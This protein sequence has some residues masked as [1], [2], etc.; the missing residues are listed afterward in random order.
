MA[1]PKIPRGPGGQPTKFTPEIKAK[2]LEAIKKGA[3]FELACSYA[4]IHFSTLMNWKRKAEDEFCPEYIKF[5]E[6]LEEAKGATALMWLEKIDKAMDEG[7][8]QAA[9]WKLAKRHSKH[10]S[11]SAGIIE[12][13]ERLDRLERLEKI[14]VDPCGELSN[15]QEEASKES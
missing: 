11:E 2:L 15:G 7:T 9:S 6:D 5:F 13:N 14:I 10:F 12:M 3:P 8:W 1:E 4:R